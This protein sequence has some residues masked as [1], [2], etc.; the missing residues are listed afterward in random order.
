MNNNLN[1]IDM[2]ILNKLFIREFEAE[3]N[4]TF[5]YNIVPLKETESDKRIKEIG[6]YL[7]RLKRWNYIEY[8]SDPFTRGGQKDSIYKNNILMICWDKIHIT[9]K[10]KVLIEESRKSIW[11]KVLIVTANFIKDIGNEIRNKLIS[12]IAT[13]ILGVFCAYIYYILFLI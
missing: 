12:H 10:G 3:L 1:E 4:E 5:N 7:E 8:D 11:D 13:F 6:Y 2:N 9:Y